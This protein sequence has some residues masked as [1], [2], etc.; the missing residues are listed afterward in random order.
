[1]DKTLTGSKVT[2]LIASSKGVTGTIV[3]VDDESYL[4]PMARVERTDGGVAI[5]KA[6]EFHVHGKPFACACAGCA[7]LRK[8][9]GRLVLAA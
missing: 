8:T 9:V 3:G 1:M 7:E 4:H 2:I 6:G 5:L